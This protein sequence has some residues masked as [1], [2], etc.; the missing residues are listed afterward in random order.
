MT[1]ATVWWNG[2][3][4]KQFYKIKAQP[5]EIGCNFILDNRKVHHVCVY[6]QP[7]IKAIGENTHK[8]VQYW[9]RRL[10]VS[11]AW[12]TFK[13]DISHKKL[14]NM[15]GYCSGTMALVLALQLGA[16][17]ID[18]LGCDWTLTNNSVYDKQ[19]TWRAFPPTKHNREKFKLFGYLS[20]MV[21]LTVV[22][23]TPRELLGKH[24]HYCKPA[25]YL[26]GH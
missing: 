6:D 18:L 5:L 13:S 17:E 7:T 19:Y 20:E 24:V 22:H 14:R 23:D 3:S 2:P 25:D 11:G 12:Q 4:V 10:Y 15:N 1:K 21:K 26:A 9:T 16:T 8:D